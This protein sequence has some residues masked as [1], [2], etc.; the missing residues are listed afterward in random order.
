M[1]TTY[2]EATD[3]VLTLFKAAW[4][5]TAY[6]TLVD[7]QNL[8]PSGGVKLPPNAQSAWA[9]VTLRNILGNQASLTGALATSRFDREGLLTVQ[10]FVP[11][12]E[13]LSEAYQL[14]KIVA[15]AYEGVASPNGVWFRNVRVNE[16]GE[17]GDF[18]QVNVLV[19]FSYSEI[20]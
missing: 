18:Y 17:D 16:I 11:A 1:T 9:R 14:A 10:V 3:E 5:T 8:A 19:D 2:E 13:G 7:Y 20:K 4:D 12:G 6:A 15:D